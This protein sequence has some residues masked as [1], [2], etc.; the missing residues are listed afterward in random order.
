[1]TIRARQFRPVPNASEILAIRPEAF[2]F[3]FDAPDADPVK[4]TLGGSVAI[5]TIRGPLEHHTGWC[6]SYDDIK[7]RIREAMKSDAQTVILQFDS[8]GGVV[9]GLADTARSIQRMKARYGKR[10]VAYS[11]DSCYS[12]AYWLAS[13]CDKI[14]VSPTGGAGSIGVISVAADMTARDKKE[15]FKFTIFSSGSHKADGNPHKP[16][17]DS[18]RARFQSEVDEYAGL[19]WSAVAKAR[20]ISPGKVAGLEALTFMGDAAVKVGLADGVMGWGDL[21]ASI[22]AGDLFLDNSSGKVT[23]ERNS[24]DRTTKHGASRMNLKA[25]IRAAEKA[26]AAA[27][28]DAARLAATADLDALKRTAA[29]LGRADDDASDDDAEDDAD[30]EDADAE[31]ADD[32]DAEDSA[33]GA[34]DDSEAGSTKGTTESTGDSEGTDAKN[35][36]ALGGK[37]GLYTSDRLFRLAKQVTGKSDIAEVFGALDAIGQRAKN[38]DKIQARLAS[39][40]KEQRA[41]KVDKMLR[42][43][44]S[45]GRV[46]SKQGTSLRAQGMKDPKWLRGHLSTLPK[47]VRTTVEGHEEIGE[48]GTIPLGSLNADQQ[49]MAASAGMVGVKLEDINAEIARSRKAAPSH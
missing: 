14:F 48:D 2:F 37:S 29:I 41:A 16:L 35:A 27:K 10:L 36:A 46:S 28:D 26:L 3:M 32:A 45:E 13:T 1:M 4:M 12:A 33:A 7:S 25:R 39:L 8:P 21:L 15:G 20:G 18:A 40:E 11:Q 9:D 42:T 5:V 19:F 31:D 23:T 44:R 38:H 43:A 17:D 24:T 30:A 22:R 34:D 6:D 49:R 47:L